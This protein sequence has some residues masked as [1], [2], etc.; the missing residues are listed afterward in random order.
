MLSADY[1]SVV[2]H[3]GTWIE[4]SSSFEA[5]V[6]CSVV[7]HAGTWIEIHQPSDNGLAL[8][9]FPTRER[10]LKLVALWEELKLL[11]RSPRGNVD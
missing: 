5:A 11:R 8:P 2:P 6:S 9:S 3:A 4:I 1:Q 7:P 10:G